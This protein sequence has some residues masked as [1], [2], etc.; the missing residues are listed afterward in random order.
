[1]KAGAVA[2]PEALVVTVALDANDPLAPLPGAAKVTDAPLT[3]LLEASLTVAVIVVPKAVL[4]VALCGV[5]VVAVM[6]A[7]GPALLVKEKLAENAP[8]VA[9]TV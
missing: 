2:T 1:M 4:I 7:A 3:R 9:V 5:P 6:D 8:V